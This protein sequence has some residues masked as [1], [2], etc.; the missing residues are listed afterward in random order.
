MDHRAFKDFAE[1]GPDRSPAYQALKDLLMRKMMKTLERV[2]PGISE[3]VVQK[4]L[5]TPLTNEFYI[6]STNGSVYGTE[7]VLKQIG[8]F[9]FR[10]KA[11]IADLYLCGASIQSHGVAG[12]GY[13]GVQTAAVILGCRPEELLKTDGPTTVHI[14]EAEDASDHPDLIKRKMDMRRKRAEAGPHDAEQEETITGE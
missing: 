14:Y 5:G 9:A 12:A 7:K 8:P 2:V 4:E 11:E 6:N 13:S 10:P 3:H 1:E